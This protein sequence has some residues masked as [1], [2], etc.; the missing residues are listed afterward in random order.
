M[1]LCNCLDCS[2]RGSSG[3]G[4]FQARDSQVKVLTHIHVYPVASFG[5]KV[6]FA[7]PLEDL[8]VRGMLVHI[9]PLL[10]L[11]L[12]N[13]TVF[14]FFSA[15]INWDPFCNRCFIRSFSFPTWSECSK[16]WLWP[17]LEVSIIRRH[18]FTHSWNI[19]IQFQTKS[20][21]LFR[22]INRVVVTT[23]YLLYFL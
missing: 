12:S 9:M 18:D 8:D 16:L 13:L 23:N 20:C 10:L 19:I 22:D 6:L 5:L 4:V 17:T 7:S 14:S 11:S 21:C 15:N 3:H 2:L 1:T